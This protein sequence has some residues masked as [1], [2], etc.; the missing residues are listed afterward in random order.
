MYKYNLIITTYYQKCRIAGGKK[1][2]TVSVAG[3]L[4]VVVAIVAAAVSRIVEHPNNVYRKRIK[5][6]VRDRRPRRRFRRHRLDLRRHR[7]RELA[8]QLVDETRRRPE[9]KIFID[10]HFKF[11]VNLIKISLIQQAK[12]KFDSK[13]LKKLCFDFC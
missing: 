4:N 6:S 7:R 8:R 5:I 9:I 13:L 2:A 11:F 12:K 10:F 3:G 1:E